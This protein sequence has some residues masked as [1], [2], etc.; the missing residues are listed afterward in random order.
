MIIQ[1]INCN[2]KFEVNSNLIPSEGRNIQCGSCNHLWFFKKEDEYI[3]NIVKKNHD[4]EFPIDQIQS[5]IK[6]D[7]NEQISEKPFKQ[8]KKEKKDF[9]LVKYKQKSF[10]FSKLLSYLI[11]LIITFIALLIIIDTFKIFLFDIFP[12][13]ELIVTNLYEVFKDI[14]LFIKDLF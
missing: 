14:G 3:E 8:I 11:V 4:D 10:S 13:F 7:D 5:S 2:K 1:C 9:E 12:N 6:I